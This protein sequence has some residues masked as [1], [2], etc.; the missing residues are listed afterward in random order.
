MNSSH[1]QDIGDD[2][3]NGSSGTRKPPPQSTDDRKQPSK[4]PNP[5]KKPDH[6]VGQWKNWEHK[7]FL[8]GLRRKGK[9]NWKA[10]ARAIPTRYV[11]IAYYF[12]R[13][14]QKS[15]LSQSSFY[16]YTH[17]SCILFLLHTITEAHFKSKH[18]HR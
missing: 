15:A 3:M 18:M 6:L 7:E 4:V 11:V 1:N 10:I 8:K 13:H 17:T 16:F 2:N 14:S 5:Y 9:G 12:S